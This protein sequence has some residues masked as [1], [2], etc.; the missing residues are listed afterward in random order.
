MY[1]LIVNSS[2]VAF[3]ALDA[4]GI[5]FELIPFYETRMHRFKG[6]LRVFV[7]L[8]LN[9]EDMHYLLAKEAAAVSPTDTLAII[10]SIAGG[11]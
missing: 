6:K 4:A 9:D 7:N 3:I 5:S 2:P 1:I 11:N 10:P 8:Y